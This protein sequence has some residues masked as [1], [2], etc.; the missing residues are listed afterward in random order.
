MAFLLP[1]N[2]I[3]T[4]LG[5]GEPPYDGEQQIPL[6]SVMD[7]LRTLIRTVPVDENWYLETYPDVA[8]AVQAGYYDNA[9]HHFATNGY[10]EGRWPAPAKVDEEWYL[11]IYSDVQ[12]AVA[13]GDVTSAQDHFNRHGYREGRA[14]NAAEFDTLTTIG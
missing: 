7:V 1:F 14:P 4:R 8:E 5:L 11:K 3:S 12:E 9:K 13:A 6:A 10:F 2:V